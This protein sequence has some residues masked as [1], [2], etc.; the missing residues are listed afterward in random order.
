MA[1]PPKKPDDKK[2]GKS[3][4]KPSGAPVPPFAKGGKGAPPF[5]KRKPGKGM[6]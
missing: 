5:V 6:V 2:S 3:D 4:A 1:F